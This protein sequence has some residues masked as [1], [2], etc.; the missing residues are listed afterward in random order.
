MGESS[1]L[2]GLF[3]AAFPLFDKMRMPSMAALLTHVAVLLLAGLGLDGF[4]KSRAPLAYALFACATAAFFAVAYTHVTAKPHVKA[5]EPLAQFGFFA[6][7]I[8]LAFLSRNVPAAA[9]LAG[10]ELGATTNADFSEKELGWQHVAKL[11]QLDDVA[12]FLRKQAAGAAPFRVAAENGVEP[13]HFSTMYGIDDVGGNCCGVLKVTLNGHWME[14]VQRLLGAR[15]YVGREPNPAYE[16]QV[17][18]SKSGF[19]VW[20]TALYAPRVFTVHQGKTVAEDAM[21]FE[22]DRGLRHL[23]TTL[24]TTVPVPLETCGVPDEVKL[25]NSEAR[26][27]RIEVNMACA[28]ALVFTHSLFPGWEAS[29]P[30]VPAYNKVM[31]VALSKGR[32][33]VE[34]RYPAAKLKQG[35]A[36]CL[37]GLLSLA[38]WWFVYLRKKRSAMAGPSRTAV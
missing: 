25:T 28:G 30:I 31:A 5:L 34:F 19:K 3:Y 23:T 33:V 9:A 35:A 17:F 26:Y 20:E 22:Y 4:R 15:F 37:V 27:A 14:G 2:H 11:N 32:H 29:H 21:A 10:L 1:W 8:G 6:G 38:L 24:V 7:A 12:A 16:K 13:T 36:L 18:E